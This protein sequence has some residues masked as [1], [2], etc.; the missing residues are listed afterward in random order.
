MSEK[1]DYIL[2]SNSLIQE[3][4]EDFQEKRYKDAYGKVSKSIRLFL[5]YDLNLNQEITNE[6]I[7]SYL[8][9]AKYLVDDI[10]HCFRLSSLVEFAKHSPDKKE[11]DEIITMARNIIRV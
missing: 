8:A 2:A 11:F 3:A 10:E 4:E 6:D 7:L 1:F 5:S 9:N